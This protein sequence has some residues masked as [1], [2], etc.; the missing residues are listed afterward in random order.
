MKSPLQ[1][2]TEYATVHGVVMTE[3]EQRIERAIC[4]AI[5]QDVRL[6][7]SRL[8]HPVDFVRKQNA[9]YEERIATL[10]HQLA[11]KVDCA[12]K[13][14]AVRAAL[15]CEAG[16]DAETVGRKLRA[17]RDDLA[18]WKREALQVEAW[19]K[20]IDEFVRK[21][22]DV[23]L[24]QSVSAIALTW[25]KERDTL[26]HAIT[27]A[28]FAANGWREMAEKNQ[29]RLDWLFLSAWAVEKLREWRCSSFSILPLLDEEMAKTST[30]QEASKK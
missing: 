19:W 6:N 3:W 29:R 2:A 14:A 23:M 16:Q 25:L 22:P 26:K 18:R 17:E 30:A 15:N 8:F 27:D 24:G 21:H 20:E 9:V 28:Q 4:E 11:E 7:D 12:G 13:L 1:L 5:A 10:Q